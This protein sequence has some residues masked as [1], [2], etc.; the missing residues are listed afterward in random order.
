MESDKIPTSEEILDKYNLHTT[1]HPNGHPT[2]V[3]RHDPDCTFCQYEDDV[4]EAM[5]EFAKFHV[6]AALKSATENVYTEENPI[7]Y[8]SSV[9][10]DS[11]LEAYPDEHIK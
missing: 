9:N 4:Q 8:S 1:Y 11:I 7:G 10:E 2:D 5:V 3:R 6:R